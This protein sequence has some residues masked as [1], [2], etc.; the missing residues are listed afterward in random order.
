[1]IGRV[2][3]AF[4]RGLAGAGSGG[5]DSSDPRVIGMI[6]SCYLELIGE[7]HPQSVSES[8]SKEKDKEPPVVPIHEYTWSVGI[9]GTQMN[10]YDNLADEDA[11]VVQLIFHTS[12]SRFAFHEIAA[13]LMQVP[14]Y[15]KTTTEAIMDWID[16]VKPLAETAGKALEAAGAGAPGKV[17]SAVAGMKL[18]AVPV[19]KFRWYVK[20][21]SM[22][23]EAGIEWHIPKTMLIY[24]GNRIVGSLGVS[25]LDCSTPA[26]PGDK[27]ELLPLE[28]K[29][30]LRLKGRLNDLFSGTESTSRE[31]FLNPE[32]DPKLLLL[33]PR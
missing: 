18:N 14:P 31:I 13:N 6:Q 22:G 4:Q 33:Q 8:G 1:M 27:P 15:Q 11:L 19:D 2:R 32:K 16:L 25:L 5:V 28:I 23:Q 26:L 7:L 29:A 30:F 20:T 10:W 12:Q 24:T 17:L 21:F 9:V 3:S